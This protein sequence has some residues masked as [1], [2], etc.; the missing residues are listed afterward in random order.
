MSKNLKTQTGTEN[1]AFLPSSL[2]VNLTSGHSGKD[3][4]GGSAS[5][6]HTVAVRSIELN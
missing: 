5:L 3:G 6:I 4:G 2:A 1:T